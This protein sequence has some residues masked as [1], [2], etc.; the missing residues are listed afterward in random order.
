MKIDR[1]VA[2]WL[3]LFLAVLL[4]QFTATAMLGEPGHPGVSPETN[5]FN[6]IEY[7]SLFK[8]HIVALCV[9]TVFLVIWTFDSLLLKRYP[10]RLSRYLP[11]MLVL[12]YVAILFL[13]ISSDRIYQDPDFRDG[14]VYIDP[15]QVFLIPFYVALSFIFSPVF[16][17]ITGFRFWN[18]TTN[19]G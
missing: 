10:S 4:I 6:P 11:F 16:L 15:F 9:F 14:L 13:F 17:A 1:L 12:A 3:S 18:P 2:T 7:F 5:I 19:R 8:P